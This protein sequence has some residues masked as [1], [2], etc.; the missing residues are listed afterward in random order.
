MPHLLRAVVVDTREQTPWTFG[1]IV[2]IVRVALPAGDYSTPILAPRAAVERKAPADF[3]GTFFDAERRDRQ[4]ER[5]ASLERRA[6]IVE[7]K[8]SDLVELRGRIHPNAILGT[9]ASLVGRHACP[10]LFAENPEVAARL[11]FGILSRWEELE[12]TKSGAAA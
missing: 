7:A 5:L 6:I 9:V 2:E 4:L 10:V 3:L 11:A 1:D 12:L 8:L